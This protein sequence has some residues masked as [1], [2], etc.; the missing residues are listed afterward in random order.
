MIGHRVAS[1]SV[2]PPD[3]KDKYSAFKEL[4]QIP[5]VFA[6]AAPTAAPATQGTPGFSSAT[7]PGAGPAA[8]AAAAAPPTASFFDPDPNAWFT[9]P[10][11]R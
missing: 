10:P 8:A 5:S 2:L 1:A 7:F 6:S 9:A 11:R 4:D 3:P